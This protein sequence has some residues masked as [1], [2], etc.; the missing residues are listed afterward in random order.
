MFDYN[1]K[2]NFNVPSHLFVRNR[3]FIHICNFKYFYVDY[4]WVI[5]EPIQVY[6]IYL[7]QTAM[8]ESLFRPLQALRFQDQGGG[9][10][11][12]SYS[13][14]PWVEQF[15]LGS[16]SR[17]DFQGGFFVW[18]VGVFQV[19]GADDI[20]QKIWQTQTTQI[21][22]RFSQTYL[23]ELNPLSLLQTMQ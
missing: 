23:S 15:G 4:Q 2:N 16:Y 19:S 7:Y 20:L 1:H 14:L 8:C 22:L 9:N 3:L 12:E 11:N 6:A 10:S 13:T 21:I 5:L 18:T 17:H